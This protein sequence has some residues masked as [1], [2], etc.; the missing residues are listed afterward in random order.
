MKYEDHTPL[1]FIDGKMSMSMSSNPRPTDGQHLVGAM[2]P[3]FALAPLFF[4]Q[5]WGFIYSIKANGFVVL[6]LQ[7][8]TN[9]FLQ[10]DSSDYGGVD[11]VHF[12]PNEI[13]VPDIALYNK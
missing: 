10:W 13:W 1:N 4:F 2:K 5:N 8:W 12:S 11:R 6:V 9:E 3:K 7:H